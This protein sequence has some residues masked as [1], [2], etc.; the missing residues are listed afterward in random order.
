MLAIDQL[1]THPEEH[2]RV[3]RALAVGGGLGYLVFVGACFAAGSMNVD[4]GW[5][6]YAAK[7]VYH[8]QR[9]YLD[10]AYT[11]TPL[12]PYIYGLP[13]LV[14]PTS[15]YSGRLISI[16]IS[17][18]ATAVG[19]GL[20][21]KRGGW[22]AVALTL[23]LTA[24]FIPGVYFNTIT[25][26]YPL[27]TLFTLL[28]ILFLLEDFGGTFRLPLS[29][30]FSLLAVL[31]RLSAVGFA[32][33]V[34]LYSLHK[35]RGRT[36]RMLVLLV[37]LMAALILLA[38]LSPDWSAARWNLF[39]HHAEKWREWEGIGPLLSELFFRSLA[40]IVHFGFYLVLAGAALVDFLHRKRLG[41]R[42]LL[43]EPI[44]VTIFG[45]TGFA[46]LH[47]TAGGW[48]REY[49]IPAW[50]A[51]LPFIAVGLV[52]WL[53]SLQSRIWRSGAAVF[54]LA[55]ITIQPMLLL[56]DYLDLSGGMLPI[57]EVQD[58]AKVVGEYTDHGDKVFALEALPV[59]VEAELQ[60]LPG[61]NLAHFSLQDVDRE[62]A[63]RLNVVNIWMLL[64]YLEKGSPKVVL[65]TEYDRQL[66]Y[67]TAELGAFRN[68]LGANYHQVY[69]LQQ[70]G[71]RAQQLR[72]YVRN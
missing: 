26:T 32:A 8:G 38:F 58:V 68:V 49:F 14:L 27:L 52:R 11:Q 18:A 22:A 20:A 50:V 37:G 44:V 64:E 45:L 36:Q 6:L 4:E 10:F 70:F 23:W 72:V 28:S 51:A 30:A 1:L 33:P 61:M 24:T 54:L 31:V 17:A 34:V 41:V 16:T 15:L 69:E 48:A 13:M 12:L 71:Q 43:R 7:Q 35:A 9:P 19:T 29:A 66:I 2:R 67:Q 5:Y 57:E 46:L 55:G 53:G 39:T 62:R 56:N 25:K 42:R 59:V 63:E 65:L 40:F 60:I 3:W 47:F 21:W